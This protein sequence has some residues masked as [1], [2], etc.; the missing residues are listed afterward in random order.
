MALKTY[1]DIHTRDAQGYTNTLSMRVI[2]AAFG[3][4]TLPTAAKIVAVVESIFGE[5]KVSDQIV[6]GWSIRVHQDDSS[7][8]PGGNGDSATAIAARTRSGIEEGPLVE[9]LLSIPGLAKANVLYNPS[10]E[11]EI[12]MTTALWA[13]VRAALVDA[14]IGFQADDDV[15]VFT[16]AEIAEVG[17]AFNGRRGPK[18][19]R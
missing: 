3:A 8:A 18:R 16:S 10:D 14:G 15:H 4:T 9:K 17:T 6:D 2:N 13:G 7:T 11:N 12:V 1:L 5:D 19:P